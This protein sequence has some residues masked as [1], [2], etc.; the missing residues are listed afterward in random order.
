MQIPARTPAMTAMTARTLDQLSGGRILLGLWASPG[1]QVVE[2]WHGEAFGKPLARTREYVEIVRAAL[3]ARAPSST[4]RALRDPLRRRRRD[5][6]R[7]AA[8]ADHAPAAAEIPIYLAAIGPKNVALAAEIADGWLPI[9][10]SPERL[11]DVFGDALAGAGAAFDIAAFAVPVV[12]QRRRPGR[13]PRLR[14]ATARALRRR[15]GRARGELLQRPRLALRLRGGGAEIQ[16]STSPASGARRSPPSPTRSSTR[17]RSS[18]R[19]SGSP[20]GSR[21]GMSQ[22]SR[23]CSCRPGIMRRYARSQT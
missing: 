1:P 18:A 11:E 7:Q 6:S 3:A 8:Q 9:L 4:R 19:A 5:R 15:H 17:S 21:R 2:G 10:L 16:D 13:R 23:P 14:Q 12:A 22:A 20:T